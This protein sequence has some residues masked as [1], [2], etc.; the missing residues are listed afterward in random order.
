MKGLYLFALTTVLACASTGGGSTRPRT[1]RNVIST[2]EI[3][4]VPSSNLYEMIEKLR[5]QFLR[6]RGPTSINTPGANEYAAVYM[7]GRSFGDIASLRS[8]VSTQVQEV[9]YYDAGG[10]AQKFGMIN[11][12]GVIEVI[13]RH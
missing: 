10:A 8:I 3:E 4:S 13:S 12:S 1:D 7:D 11:G 2:A 9:R 6:S 5:P